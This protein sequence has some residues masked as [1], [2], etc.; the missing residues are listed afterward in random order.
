[1]KL[2]YDAFPWLGTPPNFSGLA[3]DDLFLPSAFFG[4]VLFCFCDVFVD[5]D[6]RM[7][8]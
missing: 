2:L 8:L 3:G 7:V 5:L 6:I 4:A 1:L